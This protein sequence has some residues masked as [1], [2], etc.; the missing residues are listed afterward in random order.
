MG[1]IAVGLLC[2]FQVW[3]LVFRKFF[4]VF[5]RGCPWVCAV[6]QVTPIWLKR[7]V[8]TRSWWEDTACGG[9]D[10]EILP[11][12]LLGYSPWFCAALELGCEERTSRMAWDSTKDPS[13]LENSLIQCKPGGWSPSTQ[14]VQR[15]ANSLKWLLGG[16]EMETVPILDFGCWLS[17]WP[18]LWVS[19]GFSGTKSRQKGKETIISWTL[20]MN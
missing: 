18:C 14:G 3:S 9:S 2:R 7:I 17:P 19:L 5:P 11:C 1:P 4:G 6:P 15:E 13:L 20:A 12:T 16:A 10:W 8:P